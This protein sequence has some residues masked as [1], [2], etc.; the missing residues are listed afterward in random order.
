MD[1]VR[2]IGSDNHKLNLGEIMSNKVPIGKKIVY[3][4]G[5]IGNTNLY[6]FYYAF[7]IF[8]LTDVAGINPAFAG[9]I[10]MIGI[11]WDAF[12]DPWIGSISDNAKLKSGRRRPFMLWFAIPFGVSAWILFTSF[13]L[14]PTAAKIYFIIAVIVFF[15]C[16]TGFFIP[17]SA[18][19]PEM[20]QDYNERTS[21]QSYRGAA[22]SIGAVLGA[23]CPLILVDV[24]GGV[25]ES[26]EGAWSLMAFTLGGVTVLTSLICWAGTKGTELEFKD[27][28]GNKQAEKFFNRYTTVLAN[29]PFRYVTIMYL[30]GVA[31][32]TLGGAIMI[33]YGTYYMGMDKTAISGLIAIPAVLGLFFAPLVNLVTQKLGKRIG[34]MLFVGSWGLLQAGIMLV[35]SDDKPLLYVLFGLTG[36]GIIALWVIIWS[37]ISDV[38][39]VDEWKSGERREGLYFGFISLVQKVG[40]AI[41]MG[42]IGTILTIVGYVPNIEQTTEAIYGIRLTTSIVCAI[43][44]IVTVVICAFYPLSEKKHTALRE[45]LANRAAKKPFSTEKFKDLI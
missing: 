40:A 7:F 37:M 2:V 38:T 25:T 31:G 45:A 32:Q 36:A 34:Y 1:G 3:G 35:Q 13:G 12:T 18:L 19:G 4:I 9:I 16:F 5:E 33:Y 11:L 14:E 24:Y 43:P 6:M 22:I 39:E 42:L 17:Y 41:T 15:T 28:T 23:A 44:L 30:I 10:S 21:I 20:T 26:I 27:T 29:R 8:F